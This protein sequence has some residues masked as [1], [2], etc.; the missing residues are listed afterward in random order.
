MT[1]M[2]ISLHNKGVFPLFIDYDVDGLKCKGISAKLDLFYYGKLNCILTS[3]TNEE[4]NLIKEEWLFLRL[5]GFFEE[6]GFFVS[7]FSSIAPA[8]F[9]DKIK[10]AGFNKIYIE[11]SLGFDIKELKDELEGVEIILLEFSDD[12]Y[13]ES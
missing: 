1:K 10:D 6:T 3:L 5:E 2:S 7:D 11:N 12:P 13:R 8:R 4:R 9:A